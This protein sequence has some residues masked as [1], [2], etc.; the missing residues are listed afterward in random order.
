MPETS[1]DSVESKDLIQDK[2]T[3]E[4]RPKKQEGGPGRKPKPREEKAGKVF[5]PHFDE[6]QDYTTVGET[7]NGKKVNVKRNGH[8]N[9]Y[10]EFDKGG[11]VPRVLKGQ[12][13]R[14]EDVRRKAHLYIEAYL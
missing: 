10:I 6:E 5:F 3:G 1:V 11:Q 14:F 2:E 8:G 13:R 4:W 9:F 12:W 7:A